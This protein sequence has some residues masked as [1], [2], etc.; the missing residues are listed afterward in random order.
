MS[1]DYKA[2]AKAAE[3]GL[4][5][6]VQALGFD[7]DGAE[8]AAEFFG[9]LTY[10]TRDGKALTQPADIAVAYVHSHLR[11]VEEEAQE[12][13][14]L[15]AKLPAWEY[16]VR[17]HPDVQCQASENRATYTPPTTPHPTLERAQQMARLNPTYKP[18]FH[19]RRKAGA[20]E[21]IA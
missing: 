21:D 4:F 1:E 13:E 9:P 15:A 3:E 20:W 8:N 10:Y 14:A 11:D 5:R 17:L 7:M 12:Q 2:R 18:T 6:V 16:G 19:R